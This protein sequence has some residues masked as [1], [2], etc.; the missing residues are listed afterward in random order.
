[1]S[2][3]FKLWNQSDLNYMRQFQLDNM[4]D[5]ATVKRVS[6]VPNGECGYTN[7]YTTVGSGI[8][9]RVMTVTKKVGNTGDA[10]MWGSRESNE[11]NVLITLPWDTDIKVEDVVDVIGYESGVVTSYSIVAL[12][13]AATTK[14]A[15][16]CRAES[17]R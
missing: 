4:P 9:C 5:S 2:G 17:L 8:P 12:D 10:Q 14:T 1:M 3:D 7:V 15:I 11:I 16:R 13:D 6:T